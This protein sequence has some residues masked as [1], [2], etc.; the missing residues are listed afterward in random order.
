MK[1]LDLAEGFYLLP[2]G[3]LPSIVVCLEMT[4]RPAP[5]LAVPPPDVTLRHVKAPDLDW[6]RA[7]FAKVG[8]P[9]LWYS[10]LILSDEDLTAII[11]DPMVEVR[12]VEQAGVPEGLMELDFRQDGEVELS[13]FGLT[14]VL[15][16]TGVGRWLM[17]EAIDRAFSTPIR[18]LWVHTC[19]Y[20]HPAALPFYQHSGFKPY[21]FALDIDPDPRLSGI[22]P[23]DAGP[24][25]PRIGP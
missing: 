16:G 15:I 17:E 12:V 11:H 8:G 24:Q 25:V 6:F 23:K 13:F 20:D 22:L 18:R 14:A 9:W 3:M 4:E 2:K 19:N 5:R 10:R 21:R 7:L 1:E